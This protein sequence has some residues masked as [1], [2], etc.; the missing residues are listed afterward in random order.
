MFALVYNLAATAL[1]I[2]DAFLMAP[3]VEIMFVEIRQCVCE[4]TQREET[5]WR[6]LKCLPGQRNAALRWHLHFAQ[7]CE[8]AGL[9]AFPGTPAVMRHGDL[10]RK[11]YI[12]VH[13]DDI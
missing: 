9:Q 6:L 11:V 7:I 2:S 8:G 13:V 12:N 3:Q 5:H 10:N 4:L 1:D